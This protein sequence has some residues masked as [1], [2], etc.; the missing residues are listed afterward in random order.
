MNDAAT[1]VLAPWSNFAILAGSAAATLTGLMFV[2]ISLVTAAQAGRSPDGISTYSTPT[3]VHFGAAILGA[4]ILVM[5]WWLLIHPALVL[6]VTGLAGVAYVIR[7]VYRAKRLSNYDPDLEDWIWHT[8]LP[9]IAYA[10]ILVGAVFLISIPANALFALAGGIVLLIV[11][12]IHNAWD[13]VTYI[14]I[15][16]DT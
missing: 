1:T 12:G 7:L 4:T 10:S 16:R 6:A 2:V 15:D 8:I 5:P 14:A 9:G 3:V 11:V 13:V